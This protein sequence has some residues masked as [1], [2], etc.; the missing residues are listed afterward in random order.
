MKRSRR[1]PD[2]FKKKRKIAATA[3]QQSDWG[4]NDCSISN[5]DL[6]N[7]TKAALLYIKTL[8]HIES[9][10][11]RIPHIILKHQVYGVVRNKT[12]V[13]RQL[14][15][16]KEKK[17]IKMFKLGATIDEY[18]IVFTEDY[19]QHVLRQLPGNPVVDK[20][21]ETAVE[22]CCDVSLNKAAMIDEFLF[23][24]DE[25]TQLVNAGLLTVRDIGSWWMAIPGAGIFM[26][27]FTK[28]RETLLRTIRKAKY[29]EILQQELEERKLIAV[30]KL[31]MTYH[32]LDIIG[33][34]FVTRIQTTSGWLLR[35]SE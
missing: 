8:Y 7:D 9:F 28:G 2:V 23:T 24:D 33:A 1:V 18:C 14:G 35:L 12:L 4:S 32:M 34:E 5:Q 3:G 30:K 11:S 13:D 29:Q 17:E 19:K 31:G 25:I 16:L 27:S 15:Q 20:F 22:K 10:D 21:L 6:P 26:K